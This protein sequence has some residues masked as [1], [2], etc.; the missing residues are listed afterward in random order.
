MQHP[1]Q[2]STRSATSCTTLELTSISKEAVPLSTM[3]LFIFALSLNKIIL[4]PIPERDDD[5]VS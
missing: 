3:P 5:A 4:A 1:N 2:V